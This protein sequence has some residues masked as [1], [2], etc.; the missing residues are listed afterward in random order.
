MEGVIGRV[1]K[2][3]LVWAGEKSLEQMTEW[4]ID[5]MM[6]LAIEQMI[7]EAIPRDVQRLIVREG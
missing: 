5:S 4:K 3:T 7:E 1:I 6:T 2:Q